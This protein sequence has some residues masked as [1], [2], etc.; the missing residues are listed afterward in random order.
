MIKVIISGVIGYL[1]GVAFMCALQINN[2][3]VKLKSENVNL[4]RQLNNYKELYRSKKLVNEALM[5]KNNELIKENE[6]L[7]NVNIIRI[8]DFDYESHIPKLN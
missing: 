5:D 3:E 4:K 8:N 7:K 1:I 6:M 2:D